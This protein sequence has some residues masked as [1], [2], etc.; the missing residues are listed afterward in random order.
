MKTFEGKIVAEGIVMGNIAIYHKNKNAISRMQITDAQAEIERFHRARE[1]AKK[2][3]LDLYQKVSIEIGEA[4]A[5]I[6]AV[7][8]MLLDEAD[9]IESVTNM[10]QSQMVC[11][12]YAVEIAGENFADMF[13]NLKDDF[14]SERASDIR[15]ISNRVVNVLLDEAPEAFEME[16][17]SIVLAKD[18]AP[19]ETVSLDKSKVLA[20]VTTNG[21]TNSHTA[22]LASSMNIPALVGVE[23]TDDLD[24]K[25]A[26]VDAYEGM[27]IIEP[28]EA[29]LAMYQKILCEHEKAQAEL[30]A[31]KGQENVTRDG[32]QIMIDANIGDPDS[33]EEAL[34]NDARGI[35]LFRSEHLYLQANN[36]PT[37]EELFEAYRMVAEK[38]DGKPVVIRTLDLGADKQVDYIDFGNEHNPALGNRAIRVCLDHPEVFKGHL[39][40][41]LRASAYGYVKILYPMIITVEEVRRIKELFKEAKAELDALHIPYNDVPQGVMIETPAAVFISEE[42][43]QEVDFFSIGTNDLTQY[44]LA[45]DRQNPNMDA[46]YDSRHLAVLR[47]IEMT[48]QSAHK[49]G[50]PVG[51]CGELA[52][53]TQMTETLLRMGVD[54]L[55][56]NPSRILSLRKAVRDCDLSK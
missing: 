22:I 29:M 41:I 23:Y 11:A 55:S 27:L 5:E 19:S 20:F 39:R 44:M 32:K 9:Y 40:A 3:L 53:D 6:F 47:A 43:A 33:V 21:S 14:L 35:G 7:H 52:S 50:I 15:D 48:I 4:D 31:L 36:R 26:I 28:D 45:V 42:L 17:P 24:G 10:I 30:E 18:L 34:L 37:E 46:I 1:A 51:I 2:E 16:A 56:V 12:E 54:E 38:M 13:A 8:Q 25:M 49:A